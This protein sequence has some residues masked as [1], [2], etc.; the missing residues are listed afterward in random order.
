MKITTEKLKQIIKEE[1]EATQQAATPQPKLAPDVGR[2]TAKLEKTS[3]M[4]GLLADITN[5]E[6]F[7]QLMLQFIE[8]V[9]KE[10][11]K[12]DDVKMGIRNVAATVA[13][14]KQEG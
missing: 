8:M 14:A 11:L 13:K 3:G 4:E 7:E 2:V 9:S 12:P 5:R 10:K 6:E 1:L